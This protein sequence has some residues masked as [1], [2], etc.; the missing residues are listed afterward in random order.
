MTAR[1]AD[2]LD[3]IEGS[4]RPSAQVVR[5]AFDAIL[6]GAWSVAQ[7]AGF[8][9]A[10]RVKGE[11]P[12]VIVAG[13]EALRAH[14]I[15]VDHGLPLVVDTCGTG[16]DGAQSLNISTA[17][18][19][20]VAACGFPV[21]KHG[22]RAISSQSGS[23]DVVEA[24][25]IRLEVSAA[26]HVTLL[27]KVGLTFLMAPLHHPALKHAAQARRDLGVRTI[28]NALG[29]IVN[30]AG[31]THQVIGVYRDSLRG[32][33]ARALGKLGSRRAWVV[34]SDDGLDEISGSAPTR[35]SELREDGHVVE[36]IVSPEQ[37]GVSPCPPEAI[38]GGGADANA[39]AI[40]AIMTGAPHPAQDVVVI[41]AAAALHVAG[42]AADLKACATR[43]RQA[44]TDG[45][46]QN[47]L[48]RWIELT[49][50]TP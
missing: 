50:R 4:P 30:P 40:R 6:T 19:I 45:T 26:E 7:V 36:R 47:T 49:P 35:V 9:V 8:A 17:A 2:V 18:A 43:A 34:R 39:Q 14:M 31:A 22:N 29:P 12:E 13:A 20:V 3:A 38:S 42:Y 23:A 1:F 28:F 27:H 21:A 11:E 37:F 32:S 44:L 46:A 5:D 41:N 10:L 16:G 25:G 15:R 48:A 24:L 33:L